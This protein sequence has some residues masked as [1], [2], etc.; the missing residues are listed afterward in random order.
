MLGVNRPPRF[1]RASDALARST[2]A[3]AY[4]C[5]RDRGANGSVGGVGPVDRI[6]RGADQ[7]GGFGIQEPVDLRAIQRVGE[8]EEPFLERLRRLVVGFFVVGVL[9]P[10]AHQEPERV[11]RELRVHARGSRLRRGR[12]SSAAASPTPRASPRSPPTT[13]TCASASPVAACANANRAVRT[14]RIAFGRVTS[15]R[16]ASHDDAVTAPSSAHAFTAS[17]CPTHRNH[18]ASRRSDISLSSTTRS[19]SA[20]PGH[21]AR[22]SPASCFQRLPHLGDRITNTLTEHTFDSSRHNRPLQPFSP[23]S[24][25]STGSARNRRFSTS[26]SDRRF[27][28]HHTPS[29]TRRLVRNVSR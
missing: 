24:S 7:R 15:V 14:L 9:A 19:E 11:R 4:R 21:P 1:A 23:I 26:C 27:P 20:T 6:E 16:D 13:L 22:S 8:P 2:S 18:S 28:D 29:A 17:H 12:T 25:V 5:P 10:F 3:S